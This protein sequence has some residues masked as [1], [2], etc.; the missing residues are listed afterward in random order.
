MVFTFTLE[1][2]TLLDP[3]ISLQEISPAAILAQVFQNV[4]E[5]I[6]IAAFF[7]VDFSLK[8]NKKNLDHSVRDQSKR[9]GVTV[10]STNTGPWKAIN[11]MA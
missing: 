8:K 7:I 4:C 10:V 11:Q 5:R 6:S 1:M 2:H 3:A 9:V